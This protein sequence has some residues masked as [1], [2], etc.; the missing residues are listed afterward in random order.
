MRKFWTIFAVAAILTSSSISEAGC[1]ETDL[2]CFRRLALER[3]VQIE[4]LGREILAL[5]GLIANK[6]AQIDTTAVALKALRE[7]LESTG[8]AVKAGERRWYEDSRLWFTLGVTAGILVVVLS[9]V[10]LAQVSTR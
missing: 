3:A 5:N 8:A 9:A 6:D 10:V 7:S 1:G 4:S 2:P